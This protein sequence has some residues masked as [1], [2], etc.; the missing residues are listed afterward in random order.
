MSVKINMFL[1]V[2]F[3]DLKKAFDT[4]NIYA[5]LFKLFR[6]NIRG[7]FLNILE[8]MYKNVSFS[9]KLQDGL[10]D[11]F[12][13]SIGVKQGCALSSIYVFFIYE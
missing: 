1:P 13:T 4:V 5:L 9:V 12:Q 11:T 7:N 10:T 2:F 6:Y 3:F 8:N